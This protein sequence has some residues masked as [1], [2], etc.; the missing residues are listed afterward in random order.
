MSSDI[1]ALMDGEMDSDEAGHVL[2]DMKV[3]GKLRDA[4]AT[5]HLIGD[6]LRKTGALDRDLSLRLRERL[7][8]EPTI[9]APA[10]PRQMVKRRPALALAA[11]VS[12]LGVV[13][14]LA[15][16]VARI[17]AIPSTPM[18]ALAPAA[19]PKNTPAPPVQLATTQG[20]KAVKE[21]APIKFSAAAND[22]YLLAHQEFSPSYA[23]A[24]MPAYVRTVADTE[25]DSGQ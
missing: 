13:G 11:S 15:W 2:G 24:G 20:S 8:G 5:Y 22:S 23:V 14:L 7:A 1:S 18:V 12:A 10:R 25:P 9:L 3:D 4:W 19:A 21:P 16:Q 17:N 6:A